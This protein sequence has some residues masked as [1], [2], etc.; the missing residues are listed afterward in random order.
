MAGLF[1]FL[2]R[3]WESALPLGRPDTG[4]PFW[5]HVSKRR[6]FFC[7]IR[8]TGLLIYGHPLR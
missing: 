8:F 3:R 4:F 1:Y 6:R 2:H 7:E 5:N